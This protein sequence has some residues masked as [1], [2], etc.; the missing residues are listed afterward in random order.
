[1]KE[2]KNMARKIQHN[3]R[4]HKTSL[5]ALA[6]ADKMKLSSAGGW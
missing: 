5:R 2:S 4:K 6:T 3:E 1:M